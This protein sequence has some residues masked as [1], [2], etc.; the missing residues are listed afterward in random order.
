MYNSIYNFILEIPLE[1]FIMWK[2]EK[3]TSVGFFFGFIM[4]FRSSL[5]IYYNTFDIY[6]VQSVLY[7]NKNLESELFFGN[8]I[9][10]FVFP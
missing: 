8:V 10:S 3:R 6:T 1:H 4:R 5:E 2:Q 7:A 9:Y